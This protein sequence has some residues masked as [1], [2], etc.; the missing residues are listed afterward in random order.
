VEGTKSKEFAIEPEMPASNS[1]ARTSETKSKAL[2]AES[3]VDILLFAMVIASTISL[4]IV[5]P[6]PAQQKALRA[7]KS[8]DDPLSL[9][10]SSAGE[11][12]RRMGSLRE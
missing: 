10:G 3:M 1:Q 8:Y 11:A 2:G 9:R 12:A 6:R 5:S 4:V 7:L